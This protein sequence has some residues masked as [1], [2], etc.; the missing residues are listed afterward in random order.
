M[1][2]VA[3]STRRRADT[4]RNLLVLAGIG[5]C[6]VLVLLAVGLAGRAFGN[7][8]G[9]VAA[10]L[11]AATQGQ[12]RCKPVE[13]GWE[14]RTWEYGSAPGH[15]WHAKQ[16]GRGCWQAERTDARNRKPPVEGCLSLLDY[17]DGQD[18]P[19]VDP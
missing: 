11:G 17:L 10:S 9:G 3:P 7:T 13:N 15:D 1:D 18:K 6:F 16:T 12:A 8:P 5:L 2:R 19:P 4:R 14:C